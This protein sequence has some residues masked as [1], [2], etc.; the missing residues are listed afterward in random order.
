MRRAAPRAL[1]VGIRTNEC[2]AKSSRKKSATGD[3]TNQLQRKSD[4]AG[5][6]DATSDRDLGSLALPDD[7]EVDVTK[8]LGISGRSGPSLGPQTS[9]SPQGAAED[10]DALGHGVDI[11][12]TPAT[13]F[14]VTPVSEGQIA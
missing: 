1:E 12:S 7:R 11:R 14:G 2:Y 3:S 10:A 6:G 4:R 13:P 5:G 8:R 9:L